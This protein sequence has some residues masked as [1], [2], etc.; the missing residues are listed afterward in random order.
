MFLRVAISLSLFLFLGSLMAE[1]SS[2]YGW[3][4]VRLSEVHDEHGVGGL[5]AGCLECVV[6]VLNEQE[7][8]HVRRARDLNGN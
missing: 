6:A 2:S 7:S 4:L 3:L 8:E 1:W 5:P